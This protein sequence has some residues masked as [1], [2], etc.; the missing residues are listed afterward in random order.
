ALT[1]IQDENG[2]RYMSYTYDASGRAVDEQNGNGAGHYALS[3]S[4]IT[5]VLTDPL[6]TQHT[7]AFQN[8]L[9]VPRNTAITQPCATCSGT[10]TQSQTL[11][12]NGNVAS[13]TDF[14]GN[15]INYTYDL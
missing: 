13:R 1:G 3:I 15:R 8:K 7:Y 4:G 10:S 11:D 12:P 2:A 6:G 14:N 9:G 5:T